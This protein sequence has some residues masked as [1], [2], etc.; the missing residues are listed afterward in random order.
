MSVITIDYSFQRLYFLLWIFPYRRNIF[1]WGEC[2]PEF[3]LKSLEGVINESNLETL[4]RDLML[5]KTEEE[6]RFPLPPTT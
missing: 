5:L 1:V 3:L 6:R 2:S 4:K